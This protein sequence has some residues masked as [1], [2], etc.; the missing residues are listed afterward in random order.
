MRVQ[1]H[2]Q[3]A[4]ARWQQPPGA[5]TTALH[6][7]LHRMA[8]AEDLVEVFGEHGGVYAV[9]AKA[10]PHE[11]RPAATQQPADERHVQVVAGGDVGKHQ[12]LV[13]EHVGEQQI[14]DVRAVAGHVDQGVRLRDRRDD[15]LAVYADAFVDAAPEPGQQP[16]EEAHR[17]I[18]HVG[19]NRERRLAGPLLGR[20]AALAVAA[21]A[22]LRGDRR[23]HLGAVQN[24]PH[25]GAAVRQVRAQRGD[26]LVAELGAQQTRRAA[27]GAAV[28]KRAVLGR[29][30]LNPR[31]PGRRLR[32]LVPGQGLA[33]LHEDVAA[34][35]DEDHEAAQARRHR[36]ALGKQRARPRPILVRGASPEDG[37]RN[38]PQ[39]RRTRS[40]HVLVPGSAGREL[41]LHAPQARRHGAH[42][43]APPK[44]GRLG[45]KEE[46]LRLVEVVEGSAGVL[47]A[48]AFRHDVQ[49]RKI[50]CRAIGQCVDDIALGDGF[51]SGDGLRAVDR[52]LGPSG[53]QPPR[54]RVVDAL[55]DRGRLL[56][57]HGGQGRGIAAIMCRRSRRAA[58]RRRAGSAAHSSPSRAVGR[59]PGSAAPPL[60]QRL[61]P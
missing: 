3:Q 50:G 28:L 38:E 31:R 60:P 56:E 34:G 22:A 18:G 32:H 39:A 29:W 19:G 9:A 17:R 25:Q 8:A 24:L 13:V 14:V 41:G 61:P 52:G 12:A 55:E 5:R 45:E 47:E 44:A 49:Q 33:D 6:E 20:L 30:R 27:A 40:G 53:Q 57:R 7:V 23:H 46:A 15:V 36:P 2:L 37:D 11:E 16:V 48:V 1:G 4:R 59:C 35:E 42:H 54:E 21:V 10:P 26:L 43:V 51:A 58:R